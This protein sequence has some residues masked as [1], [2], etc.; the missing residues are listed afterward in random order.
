MAS[1]TIAER[2]PDLQSAVRDIPSEALRRDLQRSLKLL[3]VALDGEDTLLTARRFVVFASMAIHLRG[4]LKAKSANALLRAVVT[5]SGRNG[6]DLRPAG[7]AYHK[8]A[9]CLNGACYTAKDAWCFSDGSGCGGGPG[10]PPK[11]AD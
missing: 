2:L 1:V 6:I 3:H 7:G 10:K 4:T 5:D 11:L 9:R 8:D